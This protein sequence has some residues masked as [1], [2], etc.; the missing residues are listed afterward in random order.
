[1]KV[2]ILVT[3]ALNDVDKRRSENGRQSLDL[4][5][6][7]PSLNALAL[8]TAEIEAAADY[9]RAEKAV[10]TRWACRSCSSKRCCARNFHA[11]SSNPCPRANSAAI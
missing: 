6:G 9:T 4:A 1:M 5:L 7:T 2:Q 10:A 3:R 8:A 11:T